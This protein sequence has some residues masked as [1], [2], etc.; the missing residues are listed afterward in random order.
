MTAVLKSISTTPVTKRKTKVIPKIN[1][2]EA[3]SIGQG[4]AA[5][6]AGF[7]PIASYV[8][9]HTEVDARPWLWVLVLAGLMFSAPT[10]AEWAEKWCGGRYK[11]W[12]FTVLLEGV[13]IFAGSHYLSIA[14]LAIL[15]A[16][17]CNSAWKLA[18]AKKGKV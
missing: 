16:I 5:V 7:L 14:G 10:L 4:I 3:R 17:N 9:A 11:A 6:A 13:M 2:A 18:G 8:I 15:V 12:G 1:A